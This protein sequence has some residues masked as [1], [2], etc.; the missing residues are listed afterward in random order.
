MLFMGQD[1]SLEDTFIKVI[2]KKAV[3]W[4][5]LE[6]NQSQFSNPSTGLGTAA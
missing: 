6:S 1:T 4:I 5:E 3:D 2:L